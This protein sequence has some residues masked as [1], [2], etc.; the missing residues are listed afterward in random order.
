MYAFYTY[1]VED[2]VTTETPGHILRRVIEHVR[3][4]PSISND[5]LLGHDR[6]TNRGKINP[7]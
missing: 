7:S 5:D 1:A 4:S 3:V 2:V 6:K